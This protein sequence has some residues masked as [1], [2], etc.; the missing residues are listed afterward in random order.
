[1]VPR[2]VP[3]LQ[4]TAA[5]EVGIADQ[6]KTNHDNAD[7]DERR[8]NDTPEG[9][10]GNAHAANETTEAMETTNPIHPRTINPGADKNK[11]QTKRTLC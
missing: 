1:M 4:E 8:P 2:K 7:A 10:R 9:M 11:R 5:V 6:P 3:T